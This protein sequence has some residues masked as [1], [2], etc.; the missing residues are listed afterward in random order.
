MDA[1]FVISLKTDYE[2]KVDTVGFTIDL[3]RGGAGATAKDL[4]KIRPAG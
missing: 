2:I 4:I 3:M 1:P